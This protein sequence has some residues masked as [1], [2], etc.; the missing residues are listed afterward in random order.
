MSRNVFSICNIIAHNEEDCLFLKEHLGHYPISILDSFAQEEI[1]N[2]PTIIVGWEFI[3]ENFPS[4]NIFDKK[5]KENLFWTF[6]LS[7]DKDNFLSDIEAFFY[8]NIKRWLPSNFISYDSIN[9]EIGLLD[10]FKENIDSNSPVFVYFHNGALYVR[11]LDNN[12]IVNIKSLYLTDNCFKKT[13]T[14]FMNSY[15]TIAVSYKNFCD[16]IDLDIISTVIT[17]ENLRW[18]TMG[19]DTNEK[20]FDVIPNFDNKKYIPFF[21]SK[22]NAISLD[23]EEQKFMDRMAERDLATYWMS[24][25]ELAFSENFENTKLDFKIRKGYKLAKIEYSNK[26]TI[27]GRVTAHD[28]YN[29]QNLQKDNQDRSNIIT[30]FEGGSLLVYDYT[31]FE[32]RISLFKCDDKEYLEKYRDADLHYESSKILFE[33]EDISE[34]QRDFCKVINHSMLYGAGEDTLLA[35]LSRFSEPEYKLYLL[36]SFLK[37]LIDLAN[38][39]REKYGNRGYLVNDWGSIIRIDKQHASFNNFIQ[40]TAS[41]IIVDKVWEVRNLLKGKKSQFLFQVHDSMVFD[42]H[43]S[44]SSLINEIGKLLSSH[45]DMQFTLAYKVGRDYKNLSSNIIYLDEK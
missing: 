34:E 37:P 8:K 38:S 16:Y 23:F 32:T 35:K 26:R 45:K 7:E 11:N 4:Q 1:V 42:I 10:F 5:I 24:T 3:K 41:E 2:A 20:Y 15:K 18:V 39:M 9:S 36:K 6:S 17:I 30:R 28:G 21:M 43:P 44:E 29:P 31:S 22:L 27:T 19:V 33:S 25:R 13:L 12:F 14:K 40:S